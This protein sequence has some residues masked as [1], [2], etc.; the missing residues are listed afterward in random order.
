[1]AL[2]MH[3]GP[4]MKIRRIRPDPS[5]VPRRDPGVRKR[6]TSRMLEH[7]EQ[8]ALIQWATLNERMVP[9]LAHLYAVPNGGMRS[10]RTAAL[11]KAEGVRAGVPDLCLAYPVQLRDRTSPG[12]Y[13]EMKAPGGRLTDSQEVWKDRLI[14][15]GYRYVIAFSWTQAANA[16]LDYLGPQFNRHRVA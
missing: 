4:P 9:P 13:I 7:K 5:R 10:P 14:R 11:L 6:A 2:V 8:A 16:I 15:A 3:Q 12:L 1:M